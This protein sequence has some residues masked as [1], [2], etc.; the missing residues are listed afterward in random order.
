MAIDTLGANALASNSVT[1]AKIANDA[2]TGAKIPAD[3]VVAADIAD[4]SITT[5]KIA[6]DAVTG[7]KI[8]NSPSIANGLTLT[9]GNIVVA[10]G[11]GISF[12]STSNASGMSSELLNDYEEGLHTPT[13]TGATS[14]S[15]GM[16]SGYQSLSYQVVGNRCTMTGRWEVSGGH[17]LQGNVTIS[18]PFT[19]AQFTDQAGVGVG[20]IYLHRT[21]TDFDQGVHFG[22]VAFEGQS[23][24]FIYYQPSG[25]GNEALV[26]GNQLDSNFEGFLNISFPIA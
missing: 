4:G 25:T 9:D 6:D 21:G 5:A 8:E 10:D 18:L 17:S 16:R 11:H 7:A 14:G 26:Q 1:T 24:A 20:T 13:F 23:Q 2:V 15:V 22:L 12:A 19:V 3:A